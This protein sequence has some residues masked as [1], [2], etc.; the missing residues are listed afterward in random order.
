MSK[1]V[2]A[3]VAILV[4]AS[5]LVAAHAVNAEIQ[6]VKAGASSASAAKAADSGAVVQAYYHALNSKNLPLAFTQL[7]DTVALRVSQP[8]GD[9][10]LEYAGIEAV[11]HYLEG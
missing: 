7:S 3:I 11:Q 10:T 6:S 9:G 5:T 2:V 4:F 1:F 8:Y